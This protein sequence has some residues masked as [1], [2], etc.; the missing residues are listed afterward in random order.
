[1]ACMTLPPAVEIRGAFRRGESRSASALAAWFQSGDVD[2]NFASWKNEVFAKLAN[3]ERGP[4]VPGF[5]N[6]RLSENAAGQLRVQL[7]GV[8]LRSLPFPSVVGISGEGAQLNWCTGN[9]SVELTAF[10]DGELVIDATEA[11]NSIDLP[12]AGL[13]S[14]LKWLVGAPARQVMYAATR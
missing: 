4:N 6:F 5:G 10:A 9:R 8:S 13:E 1:M 11:G 2:Q 14:H 3:L 12:E 7:A